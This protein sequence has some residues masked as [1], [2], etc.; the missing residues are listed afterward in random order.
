[1]TISTSVPYVVRGESDPLV[2]RL[3]VV[4]NIP[5]G[6]TLDTGLV[7]VLRGVQRSRGLP[8]TGDIDEPTLAALD[9]LAY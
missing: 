4:L 7:E 5:G 2:G 8:P 1:M 9:M 3:R 6:N